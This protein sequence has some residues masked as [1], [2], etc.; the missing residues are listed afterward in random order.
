MAK[1]NRTQI[2]NP[3]LQYFSGRIEITEYLVVKC[4]E[5]EQIMWRFRLC[6]FMF[7]E[8]TSNHDK[9]RQSQEV[10]QWA[11]SMAQG[12]LPDSDGARLTLSRPTCCHRQNLHVHAMFVPLTTY[13]LTF[14]CFGTS[15]EIA[16]YIWSGWF[17]VETSSH[18]WLK[19]TQKKPGTMTLN[20]STH[21]SSEMAHVCS[22]IM[23]Y[24]NVW[25]CDNWH[26]KTG[27]EPIV[28]GSSCHWINHDK[29][30]ANYCLCKKWTRQINP[31]FRLSYCKREVTIENSKVLF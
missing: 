16:L 19:N 25:K 9:V 28:A 15:P 30:N 4:C 6:L 18:C 14:A 21:Q 13:V 8:F 11:H 5:R 23:D 2:I 3:Q 26:S 17:I 12:W 20:P 10:H 29:S 31:C 1:Q 7:I 22:T 24:E 27:C